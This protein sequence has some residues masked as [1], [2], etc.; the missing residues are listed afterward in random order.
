[1]KISNASFALPY[2]EQLCGRVVRC[3]VTLG[4]MKDVLP[5]VNKY[6]RDPFL[7]FLALASGP[8]L[9]FYLFKWWRKGG[10]VKGLYASHSW[11][12]IG[13]FTTLCSAC[14]KMH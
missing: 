7:L 3:H 13:L 1:M 12:L 14:E 6:Q 11:K 9:S 2:G 4:D 8:F 5:E 10:A